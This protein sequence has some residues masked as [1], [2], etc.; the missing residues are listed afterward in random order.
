MVLTQ[1]LSG[2]ER[3]I[4]YASRTLTSAASNYT[5]T[6]GGCLDIV[7]GMKKF[8]EF[9]E[10]F[11]FKVITDHSSLKWLYNL[12][13]PIGRLARWSLELF[14]YD[15]ETIHRKGALHHVPNALS[16]T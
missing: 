4:S 10:G 11:H 7:S 12:C 2:Q 1:N 6:E 5:V 15:F 3:V 16:R 8:R 9:L 13:N 14:K